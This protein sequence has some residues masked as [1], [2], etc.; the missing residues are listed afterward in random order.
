[1]SDNNDSLTLTILIIGLCIITFIIARSCNKNQ[2][3]KYQNQKVIQN[4]K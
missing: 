4:I 2:E 3:I 1:M